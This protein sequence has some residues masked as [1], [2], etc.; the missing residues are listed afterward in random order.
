MVPGSLEPG[1]TEQA[2]ES[3]AISVERRPPDEDGV[4]AGQICQLGRPEG[5]VLQLQIGPGEP[6][7]HRIHLCTGGLRVVE[8]DHGVA[9]CTGPFLMGDGTGATGL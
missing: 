5:R 6:A 1:T 4:G 7:L 9:E 2:H 8:D 3:A